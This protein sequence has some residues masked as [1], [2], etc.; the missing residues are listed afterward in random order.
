MTW[1]LETPSLA[2]PKRSNA[3]RTLVVL[4]LLVEDFGANAVARLLAV[5]N[6]AVANWRRKK[7]GVD[8]IH[9]RRILAL[10][11]VL[12][13]AYLT[14]QPETAMR[15]LTGNEPFLDDQR[16]IDVLV[17]QGPARVVEA[18]DAIDAGAYA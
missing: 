16:P 7:R 8:S 6:P 17:K 14:F 3:D 18:L 1:T 12:N 4:D 11:Y 2:P 5:S 9:A 10:H 15:W 13:R